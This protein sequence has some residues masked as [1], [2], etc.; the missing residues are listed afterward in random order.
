M[1]LSSCKNVDNAVIFVRFNSSETPLSHPCSSAPTY[2]ELCAPIIIQDPKTTNSNY[3]YWQIASTSY[4]PT[5]TWETNSLHFNMSTYCCPSS[6]KGLASNSTIPVLVNVSL[7][8]Q[9]GSGASVSWEGYRSLLSCG[10]SS[11]LN[12]TITYPSDA[13]LRLSYINPNTSE[14]QCHSP[15]GFETDGTLY[16][17]YGSPVG[18]QLLPNCLKGSRCAY[19][20]LEHNVLIKVISVNCNDEVKG[21]EWG[22]LL[23]GMS[24][25]FTGKYFLWNST[26]PNILYHSNSNDRCQVSLQ[27]VLNYSERYDIS[28]TQSTVTTRK[29]FVVNNCHDKQC[30]STGSTGCNSMTLQCKCESSCSGLGSYSDDICSSLPWCLKTT[31]FLGIGISCPL[32]VIV[33]ISICIYNGRRRG[34]RCSSCCRDRISET[35]STGNNSGTDQS[36]KPLLDS[37]ACN[38][39]TSSSETE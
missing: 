29:F 6:A 15:N 28:L 32:A 27:A 22:K 24:M 25:N 16:I 38:G 17:P 12:I 18:C 4:E 10:P 30:Y 21:S 1:Y 11:Q 37:S 33:A 5:W 14:F 34:W 8:G 7:T 9:A 13:A 39:D 36:G 26:V 23:A 19:K 31:T 2:R 3:F 20:G 35:K